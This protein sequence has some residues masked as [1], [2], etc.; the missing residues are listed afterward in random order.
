MFNKKEVSILAKSN[1]KDK[2]DRVVIEG[3]KV[4]FIFS[5]KEVEGFVSYNKRKRIFTITSTGDAKIICRLGHFKEIIG[6][7]EV[8]S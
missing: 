7:F 6:N 5:D 2:N 4:K 1:T 3:D 8:I